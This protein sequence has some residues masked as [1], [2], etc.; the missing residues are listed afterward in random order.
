M[1]A[2]AKPH[3]W[4]VLPASAEDDARVD[5]TLLESFSAGDAPPWTLGVS[6]PPASD[7]IDVSRPPSRGGLWKVLVDW[8]AEVTR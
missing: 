2:T 8:I 7:V 4:N 3:D 5:E 6:H 1:T